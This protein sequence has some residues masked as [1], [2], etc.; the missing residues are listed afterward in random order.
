[1]SKSFVSP[2]H[3]YLGLAAL[4]GM[5]GDKMAEKLVKELGNML[6]AKSSGGHS[7]I[8]ADDLIKDKTDQEKDAEADIEDESDSEV[9]SDTEGVSDSEVVSDTD[10]ENDPDD[11]VDLDDEEGDAIISRLRK[12]FTDEKSD[13]KDLEDEI[14]AIK[15]MGLKRDGKHSVKKQLREEDYD[16]V[17]EGKSKTSLILSADDSPKDTIDSETEGLESDEEKLAPS[18]EIGSELVEDEELENEIKKLT[19]SQKET[20]KKWRSEVK[21]EVEKSME[22]MLEETQGEMNVKLDG[23]EKHFA[24]EELTKTLENLEEKLDKAEADIKRVNHEIN[25][26]QSVF[27]SELD[28]K[29]DGKK[30]VKKELRDEDFEDVAGEEPEDKGIEKDYGDKLKVRVTNMS[31]KEAAVR[32]LEDSPTESR[33]VKRLESM[34]KEKLTKSGLDTG[35]R[36]IEVKLVTTTMPFGNVD[37]EDLDGD[38]A[39]QFQHMVYNLMVSCCM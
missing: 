30:S 24:F 10:D 12:E 22:K 26:A 11:N 33:V 28:L 38:E 2:L 6:S 36:Q 32:A 29:R 31:P 8:T 14:A 19:A 18:E 3:F 17:D 21:K 39:Q 37:N 34:I 4:E 35:G 27:D 15:D 13:I 1:M 16:D 20:W 7:L 25:K 9:G 23:L 5:V